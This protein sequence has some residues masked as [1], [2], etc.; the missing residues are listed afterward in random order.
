MTQGEVIDLIS[1]EAEAEYTS[2]RAPKERV[3]SES[4]RGEEFPHFQDD[5]TTNT[6]LDSEWV[7]VPVKRRKLSCTRDETEC[8]MLPLPSNS[9][10]K[11]N[12]S[13]LNPGSRLEK[14]EAWTNVDDLDPVALTSSAL[15]STTVL[16]PARGS[17]GPKR[18]VD[19]ESDGSLPNDILAAAPR[20]NN[21]AT[22]SERT[23]ALL[24]SLDNFEH[25]S[26]TRKRGADAVKK[27]DQIFS[28][29]ALPDALSSETDNDARAKCLEPKLERS[30]FTEEERKARRQE[31]EKVRETRAHERKI[32]KEQKKKEKEE[33]KERKRVQKEKKA[34]EKRLAAEL[35][36]V[37]K[38]KLDK[39]GSTSEMIVDL[40]ASMDGS[41]VDTQAREFLKNLGV[42][43]TLYQSR[44]P[45]VIRWR[46]K[47][48]A[49]WNAELD[50]WEPIKHMVIEEEKHV[51]CLMSA[52][53]LVNLAMAQ[54]GDEDV[55]THAT[56]LKSAHIGCIPLYLIEGLQVWMRKNK[57]AKNR[58][59]QATVLGQSHDTGQVSARQTK[60]KRP[61]PEH[62]DED[63]IEDALL[64][65]QV[66][67]GCLVHHTHTPFESAEWI[68]NFTQHISTIP[69]RWSVTCSSFHLR[70]IIHKDS[71]G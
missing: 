38:S 5:L 17:L 56:K 3:A 29:E 28:Q 62:V 36:E 10:I 8:L 61:L 20:Y 63:M 50:Y 49:K 30:R 58:A 13:A 34:K 33:E 24:A 46:R 69:Y 70:L 60:R 7:A 40:P 11:N 43:A 19:D 42:D 32:G 66:A 26:K 41:S 37:N 65:L 54:R 2:Y 23:T 6:H 14:E 21:F 39:K 67:N 31:K 52:K 44:I 27:G 59:Y 68:A 55:E 51:M 16:S 53:E 45:N 64:R 18:T 4:A 22:F 71:N 25:R 1:S 48:K 35:A 47:M 15:Y 12:S 57:T 9:R